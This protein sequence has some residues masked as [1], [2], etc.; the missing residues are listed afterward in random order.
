MDFIEPPLKYKPF[1]TEAE[2]RYK[3]KEAAMV[4]FGIDRKIIFALGVVLLLF[5]VFLDCEKK[6]KGTTKKENVKTSNLQKKNKEL[7]LEPDLKERKFFQEDALG[8]P[9]KYVEE[10]AD[11][12]PNREE[13]KPISTY[14]GA[15][16]GCKNGNCKSGQ[17][18]Y[19][20]DTGEVYSGTFKNDKRHG[21]GKIQYKDGDL[22]SG[23]FQNDKK[24]GTGTY[25]FANGAVFSGRFYDDGDSA[26]GHLI[27]GKRKKECSIIRNKLNCHG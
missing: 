14:L 8:Q 24:V 1:E 2:F 26:E 18:I 25:R 22:Y 27:V 12:E 17:G 15:A 16:P 21:F 13:N 9:K 5:F 23:Y 3:N 19:V 4:L 10:V 6:N 11:L 7:E 20:Y